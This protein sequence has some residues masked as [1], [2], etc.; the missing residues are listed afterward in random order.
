VT[1]ER[2]SSTTATPGQESPPSPR[3]LS[4]P[5]RIA[6]VTA[7]LMGIALL[8]LWLVRTTPWAADSTTGGNDRRI[9]S[10]GVTVYAP[11]ERAPAPQL[12]GRT[13]DDAAFDV[14]DL[15]GDVVVV[16]VWGSWCGPCRAET[17]GLVRIAN[18]TAEQGVSFVG[19][20]TRDSLAGASAFVRNYEVP[21]PSVF[22]PDGRALLAFRA[23]IPS[24][25]IPSTLVLDREGS[26]AARVIGAVDEGTLT[27]ILDDLTTENSGGEVS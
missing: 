20:D 12:Q 23:V 25:A 21:Y 27:T 9:L 15:I 26:V 13:L 14:D 5:A 24:A 4:H 1:N 7:T 11:N 17:P 22:D 18:A 2:S 3:R 19:I 8:A 16:N 6:L 10:T